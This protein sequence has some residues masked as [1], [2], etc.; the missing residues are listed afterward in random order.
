MCLVVSESCRTRGRMPIT[1]RLHNIS[2]SA[3]IDLRKSAVRLSSESSTSNSAS[4]ERSAS[5]TRFQVAPHH[6]DSRRISDH[7]VISD[8][9]K[10]DK[11]SSCY[12][13]A[14]R[15]RS[16][17]KFQC[18]VGIRP[19]DRSISAGTY[20]ATRAKHSVARQRLVKCARD[21]LS[22]ATSAQKSFMVTC[23]H[24]SFVCADNADH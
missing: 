10:I 11:L 20:G 21:T 5:Q 17:S 24:G 18:R 12:T 4:G 14:C 23:A 9:T 22:V 1:K 15:R 7:S 16:N 13:P 2:L 8:N 19:S 6:R 3:A